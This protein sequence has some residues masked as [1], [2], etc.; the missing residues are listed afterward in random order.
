[1]MLQQVYQMMVTHLYIYQNEKNDGGDLYEST[2]K[3][4]AWRRPEH[5]NGSINTR[6]HES[7]I[8]ESYDDKT[9]YFVSNREN[10]IGSRD[11]YYLRASSSSATLFAKHT[12]LYGYIET[13]L[14]ARFPTGADVPQPGLLGRDTVAVHVADIKVGTTEDNRVSNRLSTSGRCQA[15]GGGQGRCPRHVLRH[16]G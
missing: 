10:G 14:H 13:L 15:P 8:S 16:G 4:T 7:T 3:G 5:L 9:I 6:Y 11:I 12:G 1:M 2:L